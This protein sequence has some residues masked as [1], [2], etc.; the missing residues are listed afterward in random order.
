MKYI[1][2]T[3]FTITTAQAAPSLNQVTNGNATV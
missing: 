1:L 2:I 3:L